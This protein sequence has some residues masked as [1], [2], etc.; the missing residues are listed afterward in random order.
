MQAYMAN[1]TGEARDAL[2]SFTEERI[3]LTNEV[4]Q[5]IKIVKL[6][7]WETPIRD[8]IEEVCQPPAPPIS[9]RSID[10]GWGFSPHVQVRQ[11]E[12]KALAWLLLLKLFAVV[13]LFLAPVVVSTLSM[14]VYMSITPHISV[15]AVFTGKDHGVIR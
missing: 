6:Y 9:V 15:D 12:I 7:A 10:G 5:G 2:M 3:K 8:M 11:K 13:M 4:L 1:K 14:T